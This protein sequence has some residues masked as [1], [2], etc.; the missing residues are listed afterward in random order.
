MG[1]E[2]VHMWQSLGK[3][4]SLSWE[5]SLWEKNKKK[6]ALYC[7]NVQTCVL[8][9]AVYKTSEWER[10][11]RKD[12]VLYVVSVVFWHERVF[13]RNNLDLHMC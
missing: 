3:S 11:I 2:I 12:T 10:S 9:N 5:I 7:N 1:F 13:W 4:W 8:V 6:T